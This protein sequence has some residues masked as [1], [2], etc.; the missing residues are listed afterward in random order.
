M[1][2][3][4][5]MLEILWYTHT[6]SDFLLFGSVIRWFFLRSHLLGS[7]IRFSTF[8]SHKQL[9]T[10]WHCPLVSRFLLLKA[11]SSWLLFGT[12]NWCLRFLLIG[13]TIN[14]FLLGFILIITINWCLGFLIFGF[15]KELIFYIATINGS[16]LGFLF[17]R[18]PSIGLLMVFYPFNA[19]TSLWRH[20]LRAG[21]TTT[22][23]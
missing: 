11:T 19:T 13:T 23:F 18:P 10:L 17:N 20:L 12:I 7:T 14:L 5:G 22:N 8:W 15:N 4:N 2:G 1:I 6:T 9:T 21:T 16:F 3:K